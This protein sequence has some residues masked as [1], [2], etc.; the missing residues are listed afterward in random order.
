MSTLVWSR[1]GAPGDFGES[2]LDPLLELPKLD[3]DLSTPS[4]ASS[5][6]SVADGIESGVAKISISETS[7]QA[8]GTSSR[9]LRTRTRPA[10]QCD[11][12]DILTDVNDHNQVLSRACSFRRA[13]ALSE[14][15]VLV[16]FDSH[17]DMSPP[18]DAFESS[19]IIKNS[20]VNG[21]EPGVLD[22]ATWILPGVAWAAWSHVI[23]VTKW[24]RFEETD[25]RV[26]IYLKNGVFRIFL[27]APIPTEWKDLW[28]INARDYVTSLHDAP[29]EVLRVTVVR[30]ENAPAYFLQLRQDKPVYVTVDLDFFETHLP[31]KTLARNWKFKESWQRLI[32]AAAASVPIEKYNKFIDTLRGGNVDKIRARLTKYAGASDID[33]ICAALSVAPLT[34]AQINDLSSHGASLPDHTP[35]PQEEAALKQLFE[36]TLANIAGTNKMAYPVAV[37]RSEEF[38][39]AKA[40][41]KWLAYVRGV[42]EQAH[43]E[44]W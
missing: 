8:S 6:G 39:G 11:K 37:A 35:S 30:A 14:R 31:L 23:W 27:D 42:V 4:K 12:T 3:N 32:W 5:A 21:K 25:F 17:D 24:S 44:R 13:L 29:G 22:I 16:N 20:L 19:E 36:S 38:T 1:V 41:K 7:S 28:T 43:S 15:A 10:P 34:L 18:M 26:K 40:A 33:A 9:V 2:D